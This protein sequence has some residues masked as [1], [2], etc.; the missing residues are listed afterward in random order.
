MTARHSQST[1]LLH[2]VLALAVGVQLLTSIIMQAPNARHPG[3]VFFAVHQV[4]GIAEALIVL[5]F[6]GV[7]VTRLVGTDAGLLVPWFGAVRRQAFYAD[8][9]LH[10]TAFRKRRFP[11][12]IEESPFAAALHGLGLLLISAMAA[13]GLVYYLAGVAGYQDFPV[14]GLAMDAHR[15]MAN[16][17]WA[18]LIG[19][20]FIALLHHYGGDQNLNV[21]WSLGRTENVEGKEN[22]SQ[23]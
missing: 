4:S 20:G 13:T 19:H 10:L 21:M 7:V 17:V 8:V 23:R 11:P 2:G 5:L 18:Y 9:R 22:D 12:F 14:V 16:L 3:N 15:L 1:R 6:W